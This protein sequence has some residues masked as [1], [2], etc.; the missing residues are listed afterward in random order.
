LGNTRGKPQL[1]DICANQPL[2]VFRH[3]AKKSAVV[4]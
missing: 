2:C 1:A 4:F 3:D